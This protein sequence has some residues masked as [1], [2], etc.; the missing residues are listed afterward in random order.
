MVQPDEELENWLNQLEKP[1]VRLA[2]HDPRAAIIVGTCQYLNIPVPGEVA[3]IG[4]NNDTTTCEF[5]SP[6]ISSVAR[7]G[8]RIG[9]K[10]AELLTQLMNGA[11]APTEDI[12]IPPMQVV[13][14]ASTDIMAIENL[15]LARAI[16]FIHEHI[17][18]PIT[19]EDICDHIAMSRRW[20]EYQF[21][22]E[23][24]V[25]PHQFIC[26]TRVSRAKTILASPER[27]K[28]KQVA[29]MSGFTSSKQMSVVFERITGTT[30]RAYRQKLSTDA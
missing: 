11:A 28:L 15:D 29:L 20:L 27:Y 4:I 2:A 19:I 17:D 10:T 24:K 25:S 14:R 30:P 13:E 1:V 7:N 23:L 3:V 8:E 12:V 6:T 21:R 16:R 26:S 9:Y 5:S 22:D 18:K